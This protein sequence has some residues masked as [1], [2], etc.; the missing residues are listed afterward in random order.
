MVQGLKPGS[1]L[2]N[3]CDLVFPLYH[4][5]LCAICVACVFKYSHPNATGVHMVFVSDL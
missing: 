3:I 2:I 4:F 1:K 5:S